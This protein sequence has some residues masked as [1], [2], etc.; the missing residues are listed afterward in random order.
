MEKFVKRTAMRKVALSIVLTFLCGCANIV[1]PNYIRDNNP[2]KKIYY[3]SFKEVRKAIVKSLEE[4]GWGIEAE[5]EPA[6]FEREWDRE[7]GVQ[8]LIFTETRQR[9]F[10][11]GS[12]YDRMNVY[13]NEV[14]G[15]E[16]EVE[17][18]YVKVTSV[19]FKSFYKYQND[20]VVNRLLSKIEENLTL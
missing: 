3:A 19:T 20:H 6:L 16:I 7:N 17:V 2:Y 13:I 10:F 18:R 4:S 11:V 9:S 14:T 12:G 5:S 8:T 15:N 1:I